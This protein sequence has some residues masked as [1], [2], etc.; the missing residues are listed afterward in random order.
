[1]RELFHQADERDAGLGLLAAVPAGL[2]PAAAA[3]GGAARLA[4]LASRLHDGA[5]DRFVP[6]RSARRDRW[7]LPRLGCA[8]T[9]GRWLARWAWSRSASTGRGRRALHPEI[10]W[11]I[12]FD[13]FRPDRYDLAG[14]A[15]CAIG[16]G[17]SCTRR[18]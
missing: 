8:T 17:S 1:V 15:I 2:H 12:A 3:A 11:G 5:L 4:R 16:V 18:A 7:R 14:A 10:C 13:S 9:R 6:R